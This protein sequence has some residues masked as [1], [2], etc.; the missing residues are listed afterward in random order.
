MNR[1]GS[2][3]LHRKGALVSFL[4][5]VAAF[6]CEASAHRRFSSP[7]VANHP[8]SLR[9]LHKSWGIRPDLQKKNVLAR[10]SCWPR[11]GGAES[12]VEEDDE[13]EYDAEEY[14]DEEEEDEGSP[15]TSDDSNGVQI[16]IKVEKYDDPLIASPL[17]NLIASFGVMM[18]ARRVDLF[19][20]KVVR[21]A[22]YVLVHCFAAILA[23]LSYHPL[24]YSLSCA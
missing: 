21:I 13:D 1:S 3:S 6:P 23:P 22:R 19:N 20:P 11:G 18:L 9:S 14:D 12:I 4:F 16:E 15:A 2:T 17:T 5:V 8:K 24:F 7:V 10:I